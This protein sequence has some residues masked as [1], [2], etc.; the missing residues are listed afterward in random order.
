MWPRSD[1]GREDHALV[2]VH[3]V[4]GLVFENEALRQ[5]SATV[6]QLHDAGVGVGLPARTKFERGVDWR[7]HFKAEGNI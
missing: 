7:R 6:L 1:L 3:R 4:L 2:E 5:M